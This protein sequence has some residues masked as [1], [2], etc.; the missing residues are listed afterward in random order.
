[1]MRYMTTCAMI[2]MFYSL[3]CAQSVPDRKP[4]EVKVSTTNTH[5]SPQIVFDV[6]AGPNCQ[7]NYMDLV[8]QG[9]KLFNTKATCWGCHGRNAD[10]TTNVSPQV[11]T[12]R[13]RPTDL[14]NAAALR[15]SSDADRYNVIKNG[16][17][18]TA[19]VAFRGHLHDHEIRLIIEYLE[20]LKTG[21]C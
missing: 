16:S 6:P 1:M 4:T 10:G 8:Q 14:R 3:G 17:P 2:L 21:G 9:K 20:V 12:M 13:P 15:F 7:S 18:G 5:D 11:A 19:M